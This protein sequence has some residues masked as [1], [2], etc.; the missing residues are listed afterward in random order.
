VHRFYLGYF[1]IGLIQL[2]TLGG[3]GIWATVDFFR[4]LLRDLGP[5]DGQPYDQIF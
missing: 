2:F 4:I 3:L 1:S 5:A